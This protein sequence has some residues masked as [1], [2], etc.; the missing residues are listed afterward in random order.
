MNSKYFLLRGNVP[1][2]SIH[3]AV[4]QYYGKQI[5]M[6]K[7]GQDENSRQGT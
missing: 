3:Y 7:Q 5:A 4:Q 1:I 6:Y 2:L